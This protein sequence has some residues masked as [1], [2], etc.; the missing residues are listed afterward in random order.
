MA[1]ALEKWDI[2]LFKELLPRIYQ[3][4]QEID[5][6]WNIRMREEFRCDN[7][8]VEKMQILREGKVRMANI[9]VVGGHYVNGVSKLHSQIIKDD[10]FHE[11]YRLMPEKFG[12][13]TN[14]IASRRWLMQSIPAWT[15][16]SVPASGSNTC[17]ISAC[18][19]ACVPIWM[20]RR[21]CGSWA[22]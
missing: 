22:N 14:G 11:F 13:V 6:R 10:V 2:P 3:I 20:T 5:R 7:A 8:E 1:E 16:L 18:F 19:P 12:N 4:V 9:C 15:A 21:A 17:T